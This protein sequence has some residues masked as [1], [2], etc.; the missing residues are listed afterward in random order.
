MCSTHA[1]RT[2]GETVTVNC[3]RCSCRDS[4]VSHSWQDRSERDPTTQVVIH[5]WQRCGGCGET[6]NDWYMY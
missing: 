5:T 2:V 4:G 1:G 6:R 3:G